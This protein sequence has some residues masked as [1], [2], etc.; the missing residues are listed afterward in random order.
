MELTGVD[1]RGV[2]FVEGQPDQRLMSSVQDANR[3]IEA[4]FSDRLD[5]ALLYPA[6]LTAS[7]FDLS[8]GEAG[9]ILQKLR[10]YRIRLAV[11]CPPGDA[12]FSS[13]FGEMLAEE[14]RGKHFGVF[15]TR[16]AAIEWLRQSSDAG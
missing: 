4:C 3:V 9:E 7:F 6:N 11:V 13:R 1:E 5:A 2:K 10:N 14:R 16:V 15:E 12:G 8:S